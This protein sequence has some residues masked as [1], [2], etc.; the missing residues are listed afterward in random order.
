MNFIFSNNNFYQFFTME[1]F[2]SIINYYYIRL[3]LGM[4]LVVLCIWM[5]NTGPQDLVVPKEILE[6]TKWCFANPAPQFNCW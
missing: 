2:F 5:L 4:G 3:L 6:Y 1:F